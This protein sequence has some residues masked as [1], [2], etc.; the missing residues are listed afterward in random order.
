MERRRSKDVLDWMGIRG[1]PDW[2]VARPLGGLVSLLLALLFAGA[3]VAAFVLIGHTIMGGGGA[4]STLGTG[5][6]IVALLGAPVLIWS[7]VLKHQTVRYQ[8]EGHIT[9]RITSAVEQLGAEKTVKVPGKDADGKD[10]TIEQTL[11]NIEVRIGAILSL[12]RI[13]QDSTR[14]DKGRDHVR[15]M[16][17]VCAYVRHNSNATPPQDFPE[18]EW[19]PL[20]DNPTEAERAAHLEKRRERFGRF[21]AASKAWKWAKALPEPRADIVQALL[22]LGRRTKEQRLIEAAWPDPPI[23][24]T[25]WVFDIPCPELPDIEDGEAR[26][27]AQIKTFRKDLANW[28]ETL[29]AYSGYRLDLRGANLQRAD[30]SATRPDRSDAVFAGADLRKTRLGGAVCTNTRLEGA[31]LWDSSME[32]ANLLR[33]RLNG[34]DLRGA[35]LEGALIR[36]A[37]MKAADLSRSRMEVAELSGARMEGANL[38]G[39]RM[40]EASLRKAGMEGTSLFRARMQ[41]VDLSAAKMDKTTDWSRVQLR[42]TNVCSVDFRETAIS[43]DQIKTTFGDGSTKL[44]EDFHRPA[45]WPEEELDPWDF[46]TQYQKWLQNPEAYAPPPPEPSK[47]HASDDKETP[48]PPA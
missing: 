17:I 31:K 44:P 47:G 8:K 13:A 25:K 19:E 1:A 38:S 27:P 32:G 18:P 30:L 23:K 26:D 12:E 34:A 48:E 46:E 15:V 28:K 21:F 45:Y 29:R 5:A 2:T 43:E 4:G 14:Y 35:R 39:A 20:K 7:T 9:D 36:L 10:I 11:P 37:R 16:E 33:T 42:G 24:D 41:G 6:L 22:V 3:L 40:E